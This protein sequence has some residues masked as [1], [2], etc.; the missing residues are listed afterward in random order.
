MS[1]VTRGIHLLICKM[2]YKYK[3]TAV[4]WINKKANINLEDKNNQGLVKGEKVRGLANDLHGVQFVW[5]QDMTY[6]VVL[7]W[8]RLG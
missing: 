6:I 1:L 2:A 5:N 4:V 8:V 3:N 7:G